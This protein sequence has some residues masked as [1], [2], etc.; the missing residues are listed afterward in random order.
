MAVPLAVRGDRLRIRRAAAQRDDP[1]RKLIGIG[2]FA[3]RM[4]SSSL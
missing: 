3:F 1:P 4:V 2:P